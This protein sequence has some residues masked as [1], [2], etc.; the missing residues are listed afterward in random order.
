[1]LVPEASTNL[2]D[3][4]ALRN[5]DV[6]VPDDTPVACAKTVAVSPEHLPD[7]DFRQRVARMYRRHDL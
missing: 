4:A 2:D 7:D 6:R 3:G 1:M 5:H